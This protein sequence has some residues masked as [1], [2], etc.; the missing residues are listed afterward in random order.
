MRDQEQSGHDR[1]VS[2]VGQ[3]GALAAEAGEGALPG[4][5][6][7]EGEN[8]ATVEKQMIQRLKK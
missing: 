4:F 5:N 8:D 1:F 7:N 6:S 3:T 2:H